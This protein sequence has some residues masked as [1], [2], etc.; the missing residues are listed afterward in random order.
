MSDFQSPNPKVFVQ[1]FSS[2]NNF[3]FFQIH[4]L[5]FPSAFSFVTQASSDPESIQFEWG[6]SPV[7]YGLPLHRLPPP[8]SWDRPSL[9]PFSQETPG[10]PRAGGSACRLPGSGGKDWRPPSCGDTTVAVSMRKP[11]EHLSC[12]ISN[13]CPSHS[14]VYPGPELNTVSLALEAGRFQAP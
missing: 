2:C 6:L 14:E 13:Q 7:V 5:S 1:F 9:P 11:L 4:F 3:C 10:G 8:P 12:H